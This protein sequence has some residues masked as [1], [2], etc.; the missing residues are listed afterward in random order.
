MIL[1]LLATMVMASCG[2]NGTSDM[3]DV[4]VAMGKDKLTRTELTCI[5]PGGLSEADSVNYAHAYIRSW[6]DTHLITEVAAKEID[7]TKIDK[8]VDQY[9]KELITWEYSRMVY[10]SR[11]HDK[12]TEDSIHRYYTSHPDEFKLTRPMVKGIYIKVTND[13]ESLE[14]LRNLYQSTNHDAL[15]K[16]EKTG[17]KGAMH[18]DYFMDK[19]IDW[20]QIESLIPYNFGYDGDTFTNSQRNVDYSDG[21]Y[22][23]LLNITDVLH[24]GQTMPEEAARP[25]I[26][27]R[28]RFHDRRT[29]DLQ[30]KNRLYEKAIESGSLVINC[31]VE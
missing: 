4:L 30:L 21:S 17:L 16:I 27:E 12:I 29:F 14:E 11:P 22:T 9:R 28:L 26:E 18:Y 20:E 1:T 7:M 25:L 31:D 3:S 15:D 23:Y 8:L 2:I 24:T 19:W 10:D 13:S 6:I 5:M